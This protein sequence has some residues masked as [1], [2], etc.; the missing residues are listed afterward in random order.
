MK[1]HMKKHIVCFGDSNTHGYCAETGMRFDEET[2]WSSLLQ[3]RLGDE[4][5]VIEEGLNGRTAVFDDPIYGD[6]SGLGYISP[7]LLTHEPVDLLI[8]MLGTNDTKE[9]F[10][11]TPEC[12]ALGMRRLLQKAMVTADA[13]RGGVPAVLLMT[14]QNIDPRY[15]QAALGEIMGDGCAEKS[16][17]L[18][19]VYSKLADDLG[20]WYLD[21]NQEIETAPNSVDYMHLTKEGHR[22]LADAVSRKV[23]DIFIS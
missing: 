10:G 20:C 1:K 22:Q 4:F 12:I 7:C 16:A 23:K 11:C 18:S 19:A 3:K 15:K 2:R 14:P 8:V 21:V 6:M 5:L 17:G 9:R 13:W